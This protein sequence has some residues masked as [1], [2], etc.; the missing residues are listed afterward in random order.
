MNLSSNTIGLLIQ[1]PMI[2]IGQG[3]SD[4]K[5]YSDKNLKIFKMKDM[6]HIIP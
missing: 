1:G 4:F 2:S 3:A 5:A 6:E